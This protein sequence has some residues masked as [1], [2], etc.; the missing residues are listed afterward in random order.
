M[1]VRYSLLYFMKTVSGL[2]T[3]PPKNIVGFW[4]AAIGLGTGLTFLHNLVNS[5]SA[6]SA[7]YRALINSLVTIVFSMP[8]LLLLLF[9]VPWALR[10]PAA[11]YCWLRLTL[12]QTISAGLTTLLL[13][14]AFE[15]ERYSSEILV[16]AAPY[17]VAGLL[18]AYRRYRAW[19]TRTA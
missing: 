18:V 7:F 3:P 19:L 10:K 13:Y 8:S 16:F 15:H 4:L 9:L 14:R 2:A 5:L 11:I 6:S 12:A 17:V 1:F